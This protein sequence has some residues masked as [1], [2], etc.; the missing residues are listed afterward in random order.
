MFCSKCGA[1]IPDD[2]T[3][4]PQ[5]GAPVN[6]TTPRQTYTPPQPQVR[7]SNTIAVVGLVLAFF[8]PLIGFICSIIG[9]NKSKQIGGEGRGVAIAGIVVSCLEM[10]AAILAIVVYVVL[11]VGVLETAGAAVPALA[12]L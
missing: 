6:K 2:A 10:G 5:C 8:M 9:L 3:V 4:C 1:S 12:L 7:E 11:I